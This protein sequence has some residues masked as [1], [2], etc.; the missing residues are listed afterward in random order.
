MMFPLYCSSPPWYC[1]PR[2]GWLLGGSGV[3]DRYTMFLSC[4][5]LPCSCHD[6]YS[7]YG[8]RWTGRSKDPY[9]DPTRQLK[10]CPFM[11]LENEVIVTVPAFPQAPGFLPKIDY[12]IFHTCTEQL[13]IL[14]GPRMGLQ[15]HV[16]YA[17][18]EAVRRNPKQYKIWDVHFIV[19]IYRTYIDIYTIYIYYVYIYTFF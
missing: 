11:S 19:Y 9:I 13:H 5:V 12:S 4:G 3:L 8:G 7:L 17:H 2:F 14:G 18:A 15:Q 16:F 10:N 6:I 1:V